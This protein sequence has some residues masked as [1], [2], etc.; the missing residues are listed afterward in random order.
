MVS[1]PGILRDIPPES[2]SMLWNEHLNFEVRGRWN[3]EQYYSLK[4]RFLSF[5]ECEVTIVKVLI[6][7]ILFYMA[8]PFA[9]ILFCQLIVDGAIVCKCSFVLGVIV[10]D[11]SLYTQYLFWFFLS[12]PQNMN[13]FFESLKKLFI[14][15]FQRGEELLLR[16]T[17]EGGD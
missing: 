11:F 3:N 4:E 8:E 7:M 10:V 6:S 12:L 2:L 5:F 16:K 13:E 1:H 15:I 9:F 17:A 14:G